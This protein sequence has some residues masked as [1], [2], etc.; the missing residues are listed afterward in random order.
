MIDKKDVEKNPE[1]EMFDQLPI[2]WW[3]APVKINSP[4][5]QEPKVDAAISKRYKNRTK[6]DKMAPKDIHKTILNL[7]QD[8]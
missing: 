8:S 6:R 7:D 5:P 2:F 3:N 4:A 1:K